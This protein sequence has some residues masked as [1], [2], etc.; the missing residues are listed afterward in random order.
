MIPDDT[1]DVRNIIEKVA[2]EI[3]AEVNNTENDRK[4]YYSC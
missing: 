1:D 3:S 4:K 2:K